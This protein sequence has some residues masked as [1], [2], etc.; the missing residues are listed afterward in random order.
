MHELWRRITWVRLADTRK[1]GCAVMQL[2][3]KVWSGR[4]AQTHASCGVFDRSW[5]RRHWWE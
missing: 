2:A 3:S 5:L 4:Y 1:S